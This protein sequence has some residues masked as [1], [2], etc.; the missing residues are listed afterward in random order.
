MGQFLETFFDVCGVDYLGKA[1]H[2]GLMHGVAP[3]PQDARALTA[4]DPILTEPHAQSG[5]E[6]NTSWE[7]LLAC[8]LAPVAENVVREEPDVVFDFSGIR[9]GL[10]AKVQYGA[11]PRKLVRVPAD[12]IEQAEVDRDL[13]ALNYEKGRT[14]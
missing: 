12:Q 1:L 2:R 4:G 13:I 8:L 3:R 5:K 11:S 9:Y 6:R 10:A 7:Y 14:F